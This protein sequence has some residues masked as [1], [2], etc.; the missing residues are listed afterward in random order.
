M[1]VCAGVS[2]HRNECLGE[3]GMEELLFQWQ[4]KGPLNDGLMR[5]AAS[6]PHK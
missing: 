2:E 3:E 6:N 4:P 1:N 5:L